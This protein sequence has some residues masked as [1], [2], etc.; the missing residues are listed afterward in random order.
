MKYSIIS[1]A[2]LLLSCTVCGQSDLV[3]NQGITSPLHQANIGKITFMSK[4]IPIENYKEADF[5]KT[6]ELKENSDLSIRT[7]MSNSLTNY[8]HRLAPELTA[9]ELTKIGNYQFS[10]FV[11]GSLIYKENL[12]AGAGLAES[13]NTITVFRVPLRTINRMHID[14]LIR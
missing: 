12:H 9:D 3:K 7:F 14:R 4:P 8:L 10:F 5:L 2:L 1:L 13:K 6:F 11:D